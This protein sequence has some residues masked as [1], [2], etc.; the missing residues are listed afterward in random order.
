MSDLF[1]LQG[2]DLDPHKIPI[3]VDNV[4][5]LFQAAFSGAD[6]TPYERPKTAAFAL[7]TAL[8]PHQPPRNFTGRES[9]ISKISVAFSTTGVIVLAGPGG[10][11]K[12]SIAI[13]YAHLHSEKYSHILWIPCTSFQSAADAIRDS[14]I[15]LSLIGKDDEVDHNTMY[16]FYLKYLASHTDY[17]LIIDNAD[18]IDTVSAIFPT[19]YSIKIAGHAIITSRNDQIGEIFTMNTQLEIIGKW[20]PISTER[21]LRDRIR[22]CEAI[23]ADPIERKAFEELMSRLDGYP[24]A[25]EQVASL[26][27]KERIES[28]VEFLEMYERGLERRSDGSE[29]PD[30]LVGVIGMQVEALAG[31][32]GVGKAALTILGVVAC[33]APDKIPLDLIKIA[34]PDHTRPALNLLHNTSLLRKEFK[35]ISIHSLVQGLALNILAH[36]PSGNPASSTQS[37][38]MLALS[39]LVTLFPVKENNTFSVPALRLGSTL[40]PHVLHAAEMASTILPAESLPP[41]ITLLERVWDMAYMMR[42]HSLANL[43]GRLLLNLTTRH[44]NGRNNL[45]VANILNNLGVIAKLQGDLAPAESFYSESHKFYSEALQIKVA[46]CGTQNAGP[47]AEVLS[48][49]GSLEIAQR[50]LVSAR[51][52]FEEALTIR[53]GLYGT[54]PHK[55]IATTLRNLGKLA[56]AEG[57]LVA[58]RQYHSEALDIR[59]AVYGGRVNAFV[60]ESLT[61]MGIVSFDMG[62]LEA[63]EAYHAEALEVR[64]KVYDGKERHAFVGDSMKY[65]GQVH[66]KKGDWERAEKMLREALE[67]YR[68]VYGGEN[69]LDVVEVKKLL[70]EVASEMQLKEQQAEQ[71]AANW[72]RSFN[73]FWKWYVGDPSTRGHEWD[74]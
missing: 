28:F 35:E 1:K 40:T 61:Y 33:F 39:A 67:V 48:N 41:A 65:L 53:K 54:K 73:N 7:K 38:L 68:A 15:I 23:L 63:A 12:T 5:D 42:Y 44:H 6:A 14:C 71:G 17:L 32:G 19:K 70:E 18:E 25:I 31:Q 11:G 2:A 43:A 27:N 34:E 9:T 51:A 8:L 72:G 59:T 47:V 45:P 29:Y 50:N 74:I 37:H 62:D 30:S 60:A 56:Q 10:I 64:I 24:L 4:L 52:L 20:S 3:V 69:H 26:C 49:M 66:L 22:G 16:P 58:A 57:D 55:Y 21:F 46:V 13:Q 36:S